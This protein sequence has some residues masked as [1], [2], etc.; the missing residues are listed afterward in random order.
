MIKGLIVKCPFCESTEIKV[1]DS[2]DTESQDAVRRRRECLVCQ[3]R[4][5][6]YERVEETPLTVIKRGGERE[7]FSR[8]KLLEG[9]LRACEK[10]P[11][12]TA[13][14]EE[15]VGEIE[16]DIRNDFKLEVPSVEIGDRTLARLKQLDKVA[17]VRFASVY[18]QFEDEEDFQRELSKL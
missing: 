3:R 14:L 18:K 6:T 17:Y 8:S 9:L 4:F 15:L 12:E 1:V 5:T 11:I 10:R 13:A 7:V 16:A 2:R